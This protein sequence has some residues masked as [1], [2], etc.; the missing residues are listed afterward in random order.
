MSAILLAIL[1]ATPSV[2]I[3]NPSECSILPA[4]LQLPCARE[5]RAGRPFVIQDAQV[6]PQD[7]AIVGRV[8]V[9]AWPEPA[10]VIAPVPNDERSARAAERTASATETLATVAVVELILVI[11]LAIT[12]FVVR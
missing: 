10:S 1:L 8:G 5:T 4:A 3:R 9:P 6:Q 7:S 11:G 2:Q 12:F